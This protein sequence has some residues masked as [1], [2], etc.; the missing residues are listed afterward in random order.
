VRFACAAF[1]NLT[2][3]HLDFHA[4]M[5]AYAAAKLR[6]FTELAPRVVVFNK[7]D[8][9]GTRIGRETRSRAVSVSRHANADVYPVEARVDSNGIRARVRLP[10]GDVDL[11]SRL[12]G[13][14]NLQNLLITLAAI[15]ALGYSA[16]LA[17]LALADAPAVPG[18][19]E[20]CDGDA[21]DL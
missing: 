16:E 9:L 3:D 19:L 7:D 5:E 13:E 20:R 8:P 4:S 6:L 2:Q 14:H 21:D 10:S 1:T 17:A 12:L 11:R 18:R 15:E